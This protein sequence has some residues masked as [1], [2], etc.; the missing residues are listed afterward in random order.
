VCCLQLAGNAGPKKSPSGTITQLCGAISSRVPTRPWKYLRIFF[1]LNLR[2]PTS[3][4]LKVLECHYQNVVGTLIFATKACIDN[5]KKKLVKQQCLRHMSSQYGE[6]WPTS[7]WDLLESLRHP[8]KF[9]RVSRL[10]SVT[11]LHSSCG[12]Q[13]N[14]AALNRGHCLYSA[15]RPSHWALAHISST[16]KQDRSS[17]VLEFTKLCDISNFVKEH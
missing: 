1:L 4:S 8:C 5:W 3:G 12:H 2:H 13:P 11:A 6:R 16:W 10:G 14:F 9:Q 7:G 15:G 17:K